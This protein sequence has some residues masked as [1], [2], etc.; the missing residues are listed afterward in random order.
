MEYEPVRPP[1]AD[2]NTLYPSNATV[3]TE[4]GDAVFLSNRGTSVAYPDSD[5]EFEMVR[6]VRLVVFVA[7]FV[8]CLFV[9]V[10]FVDVRHKLNCMIATFFN[11]IRGCL[12][13]DLR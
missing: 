9:R 8:P 3:A 1:L 10:N 5:E 7:I 4:V 6:V 2:K 12:V 11:S 13:G